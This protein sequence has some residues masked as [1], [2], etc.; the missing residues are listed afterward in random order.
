M[1]PPNG[2]NFGHTAEDVLNLVHDA[3]D[4]HHIRPDEIYIALARVVNVH[5]QKEAK[6]EAYGRQEG[7]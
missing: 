7:S 3:L 2:E 4:V 1:N 5:I 6:R